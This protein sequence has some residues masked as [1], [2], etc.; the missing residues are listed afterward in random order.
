MPELPDLEVVKKVLREKIRQS[1]ITR[2]D[3]KSPITVKKPIARQL[4]AEIE[5]ITITD[6]DRRGKMLI[7]YLDNGKKIVL[8]MMLYGRLQY[9]PVT[10]PLTKDNLIIFNF[11]GYQLRLND[12]RRMAKLYCVDD[13][14]QV[15][16]LKKLGP[17]PLAKNFTLET[18]QNIFKK[19]WTKIKALLM[20]QSK[21]AGIGNAYADEILFAAGIHPAKPATS[22]GL[23]EQK[24][25]FTAM[26]EVMTSSMEEIIS[27][28][29]ERI[30][31]EYRDHLK[32]HGRA[33]KPCPH[34]GSIIA[35]IKIGGRGT[36]FCPSCQK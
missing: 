6:I 33:G 28:I 20:D 7:F 1:R 35:G 12:A 15:M 13:L 25:L 19:Q 3:I 18:L 4:P 29:G 30:E 21:I 34:C 9:C 8:H 23:D 2:V 5:G 16:E 31:V 27:H 17:E 24:R 14:T 10:L 22:L 11:N 32:V 36:A 26:Q